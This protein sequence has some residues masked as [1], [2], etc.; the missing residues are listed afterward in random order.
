M[1]E[2]EEILR[3]ETEIEMRRRRDRR[4][5]LEDE[6]EIFAEREIR[7]EDIERIRRSK[8]MLEDHRKIK[9]RENGSK[10]RR[11]QF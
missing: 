5:R 10:E 3:L 4:R 7:E 8:F 1:S 11:C 9:S 2:S 6:V